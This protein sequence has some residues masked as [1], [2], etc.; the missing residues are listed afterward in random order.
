MDKNL[1]HL[2]NIVNDMKLDDGIND[3]LIADLKIIKSTKLQAPVPAVYRPCLCLIIQGA[4]NVIVGDK[5]YSYSPGEYIFC[6]VE[7]P[8][9]G[10]VTKASTARPYLCLMIEV[11]STIVFD[12][13]KDNPDLASEA[14]KDTSGTFVSKADTR[15]YEA[16]VRLIS[17]LAAAHEA[18]YLST[19]IFKEIIFRILHDHNGGVVRQMGVAGSQTQRITI[20]VGII[21]QNYN[22]TLNIEKL[23]KEVGMSSSSFHKHFK[24]ITNMSP[25]QYQKLVRLQE[26]R[27]LLFS[28]AGDAASIGFTV[29]YESP[30]Q[31]SREYSRL[32]GKPPIQDLKEVKNGVAD[33]N[34]RRVRRT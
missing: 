2:L 24:D 9:T 15:L 16:F 34:Q 12:V 5:I 13:L 26:A 22:S 20:A 1:A 33:P 21:K 31:F 25:L 28:N 17:S 18:K 8:V 19:M 32:F 3:T 6:S 23:A 29:G 7:V 11:E 14:R 27:R 10:H 4:K 30:S